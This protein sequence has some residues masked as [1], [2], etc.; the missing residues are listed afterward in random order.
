MGVAQPQPHVRIQ[1]RVSQFS[2]QSVAENST[3]NRVTSGASPLSLSTNDSATS[4]G[5]SSS[6]DSTLDCKKYEVD[7]VLSA[8][9]IDDKEQY[10]Y[11]Q[12]EDTATT[13][14]AQ[15]DSHRENNERYA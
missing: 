12:V 4:I 8:A 7:L 9:L 6:Q 15:V 3:T 5:T 2:H 14:P 13:E 1:T 11:D 10:A